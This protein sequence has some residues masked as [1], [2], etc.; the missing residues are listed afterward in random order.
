MIIGTAGHVD[1]GKTA[2]V[3]ALTGV[4]TDRLPEEKRRGITLELG[5]AQLELPGGLRA[6]VVDVPGHERFIKAMAAGAGGVDVVILVVALDEGVMPQ[7][8]EHLDICALLGVRA[9]VIAVTKSD[10]LPELG[11]DWIPLLHDDLAALTLGTFLENAK[12]I[13]CSTKSS[14]GLE[15]LKAELA[16]LSRDVAARPSEGAVFLPI[17]RA[18][19][20]KGFGTVVTGTLLSGTLA[21]EDPVALLPGSSGPLR[22]RGLQ[23]HGVPVAH[24]TAGQRVAVNLADVEVKSISRGQVLTRVGELTSTRMLD[25]EVTLLPSVEQPLPRQQ[26]MLL[27]IG[28]AQV[29]ATLALLDVAALEPGQSTLGQLRM[30]EPVAA[31]PHQRFILRG[32]RPLSGRGATVAGGR[33]LNLA[34]RRLRRGSGVG[35]LPL[36]S[37][38]PEARV[39]WLLAQAG[40]RGLDERE[41]LGRSGLAP[42]A[43]QRALEILPTRG[44][45]VLVDRE[46]RHFIAGSVLQALDARARQRLEEFHAREPLRDALPKEEL[47][48]RLGGGL[49][50]RVHERLLQRGAEAGRWELTG[51]GVRLKGRGRQFT[52]RERVTSTQVL[53]K[54]TAARLAPPRV[55]ELETWL[56]LPAGGLL[57]VLAGMVSQGQLVRVSDELYFVKNVVEGLKQ[58]LLLELERQGGLTTQ[59]FK[60]LVGESRKYVI[61]LSEYFDRERV[62]LRVGDKRV[63]RPLSSIDAAHRSG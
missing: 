13:A 44:T 3:K 38:T 20:L 14:E 51:E 15:P 34:T 49:A 2:L 46:R 9:G 33:V 19:T 35:L 28:T 57:P 11:V 53:E 21:Q 32:T 4:D 5:F 42:R 8:R 40:Y 26:K 23:V 29:E 62:T 25:V 24:A 61:P 1:H 37:G 60:D 55:A 36:L 45:A 7:T 39:A 56:G 54:L 18:F 16:R 59:G 30:S 41:L 52:E 17:D 48:Q 12:V 63:L 43:V 58:R 6:G 50:P 10:L 31:L 47:R 27:H 22:I